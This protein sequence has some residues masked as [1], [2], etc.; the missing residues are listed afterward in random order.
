MK[1]IF[2]GTPAFS[3]S[4]LAALIQAGEEISLVVTQPDRPVGRGQKL[5][6]SPVK[7]LALQYHLP[8]AQPEKIKNDPAFIQLVQSLAPDLCVV[9]AFGQILPKDFL[10]IPKYGSINTHASLLPKYR[11]ASPIQAALRAGEKRTGTTIMF[12][13]ERMD[14]GDI[15]L[16]A[17]LPIQP[18]DTAG[19]LEPKL[20]TL[21]ADALLQTIE[22]VKNGTVKPIPQDETLA[23]Y[24]K[25]LRKED[26]QI[27]WAWP[28]A[29]I[30]NHVRAMTPWPGAYTFLPTGKRVKVLQTKLQSGNLLIQWVQPEGKQ[31]MSYDAYCSGHPPIF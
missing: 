26:G 19:I 13:N 28:P 11:G 12:M 3:V 15:L 7:E 6:F 16:Q 24:T 1:I 20:A 17:S 2:L 31:P 9:S 21:S 27:D 25:L 14:A 10:A 22:Q 18:E 29:K 23:T 8:V 5:T 4:S 30:H